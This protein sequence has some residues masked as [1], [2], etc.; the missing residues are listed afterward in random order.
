MRGDISYGGKAMTEIHQH[1]CMKCRKLYDCVRP[2]MDDDTR[3]QCALK[4]NR[5]SICD[6]CM[7]KLDDEQLIREANS[8][9]KV[10]YRKQPIVS[11]PHIV[12]A[13]DNGDNV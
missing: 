3:I 12:Y 13:G 1:L 11:H 6:A 9:V 5:D 4:T 2:M 10:K 7:L 8:K